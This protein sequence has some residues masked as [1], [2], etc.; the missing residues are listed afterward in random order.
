MT[1]TERET[2]CSNEESIQLMRSQAAS[3]IEGQSR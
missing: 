2:A 3:Q 1:E